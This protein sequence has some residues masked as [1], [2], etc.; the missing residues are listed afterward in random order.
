ML[1]T[2]V[3]RD[4]CARA[5]QHLARFQATSGDN[6]LG[7]IATRVAIKPA[8]GLG[9]RIALSKF[10]INTSIIISSAIRRIQKM[11]RDNRIL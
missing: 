3:P 8:L 4:S 9:E 1:G 5:R 6:P 2:I 11:L 10:L 7:Y